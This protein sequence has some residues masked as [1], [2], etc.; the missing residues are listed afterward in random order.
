MFL[1]VL[2]LRKVMIDFFKRPLSLLIQKNFQWGL[3][4]QEL[5]ENGCTKKEIFTDLHLCGQ[6]C[7]REIIEMPLKYPTVSLK[8]C[9]IPSPTTQHLELWTRRASAAE[10]NSGCHYSQQIEGNWG[11]NLHTHYWAI[12]WKKNCFIWQDRFQLQQSGSTTR[13]EFVVN[14]TKSN[15]YPALYQWV[16]LPLVC[17]GE[18]DVP[19]LSA[20]LFVQME[21]CW[22]AQSAPVLLMMNTVCPSPDS[23]AHS[24]NRKMHQIPKWLSHEIGLM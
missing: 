14:N 6:K 18:T 10:G 12:A 3:Y 13:S 4:A 24:F 15:I 23:F 22:S 8:D 11:N 1:N 19:W 5:T 7:G 21:H 9:R 20:G 17:T 2:L 16:R